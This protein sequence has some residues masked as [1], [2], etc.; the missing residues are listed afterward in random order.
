[1]L[2]IDE[3]RQDEVVFAQSLATMARQPKKKRSY[4]THYFSLSVIVGKGVV[5]LTAY[6]KTQKERI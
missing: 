4:P 5:A 2:F 3:F 1:L 6:T